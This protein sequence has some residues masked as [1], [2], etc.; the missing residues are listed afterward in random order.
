MPWWDVTEMTLYLCDMHASNSAWQTSKQKQNKTTKTQAHS[1]RGTFY[2][3]A[4]LYSKVPRP[5]EISRVWDSVTERTAQGNM[6]MGCNDSWLRSCT[7][8]GHWT[9]TDSGVAEMAQR[10]RTFPILA[11]DLGSVL[12][13][14]TELTPVCNPS[15]RI[16]NVLIW[17]PQTCLSHI[18]MWANYSYT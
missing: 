12:D 16:S 10:L 1:N 9:E 11:E 14:H 18:N 8:W 3:M 7:Q 4:D 6:V 13:T 5:S 2:I 17:P 15:S